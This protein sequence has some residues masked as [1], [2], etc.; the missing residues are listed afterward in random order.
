MHLHLCKNAYLKHYRNNFMY[1]N[2]RLN[3]L[4]TKKVITVYST[5]WR[6]Y[7]ENKTAQHSFLQIH[8]SWRVRLMKGC[9]TFLNLMRAS[10]SCIQISYPPYSH[11]ILNILLLNSF[12]LGIK[13]SISA[14][15]VIYNRY[16]FF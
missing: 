12:T 13:I 4:E 7:A 1:K 15:H 8:T 16:V 5:T 2:Y 11:A 9:L 14:H 3:V 6:L 10:L